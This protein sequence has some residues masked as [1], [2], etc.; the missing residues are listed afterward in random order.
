[1]GRVSTETAQKLGIARGDMLAV[2]SPQGT[3]ELPAYVSPTLHP[4]AVAIPL[5]HRYTPYQQRLQ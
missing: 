4:G 5:G 1:V 2:K 3:L